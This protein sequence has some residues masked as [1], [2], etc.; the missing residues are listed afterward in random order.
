MHV[1]YSLDSEAWN[2]K[3]FDGLHPNSEGHRE[4]YREVKR[5]LFEE[6]EFDHSG[7]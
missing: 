1:P 5:P 7:Q 6:L 3:L 2:A 4:I